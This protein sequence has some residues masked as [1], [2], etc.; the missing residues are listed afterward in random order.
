MSNPHKN[1]LLKTYSLASKLTFLLVLLSGVFVV[2]AA[3]GESSCPV[4]VLPPYRDPSP[5]SYGGACPSVGRRARGDGGRCDSHLEGENKNL[6]SVH[7]VY[8]MDLREAHKPVPPTA[9]CCAWKH[10]VWCWSYHYS[11]CYVSLTRREP[12]LWHTNQMGLGVHPVI[13]DM[14]EK[15]SFLSELN[16]NVPPFNFISVFHSKINKVKKVQLE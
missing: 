2:E 11:V 1:S 7:T 5:H 12:V 3:G 14:P 6:L 4:P 15:P 8:L 9:R 10:W 16:R 13:M